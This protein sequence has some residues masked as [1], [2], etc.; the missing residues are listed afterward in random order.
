MIFCVVDQ[1]SRPRSFF[2]EIFHIWYIV[3]ILKAKGST[4]LFFREKLVKLF[5]HPIFYNRDPKKAIF[6]LLF[7][8]KNV[9]RPT[10]IGNAKR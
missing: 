1:F 5:D 10:W 2:F 4:E 7:A 3:K 6:S 8:G 9:F